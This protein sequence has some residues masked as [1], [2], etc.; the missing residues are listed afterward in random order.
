[1]SEA[2]YIPECNELLYTISGIIFPI[3]GECL[4]SKEAKLP[5]KKDGT[6]VFRKIG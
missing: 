3:Q 2:L 5:K 4:S 6:C 1:M